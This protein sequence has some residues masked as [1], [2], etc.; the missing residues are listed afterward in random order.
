MGWWLPPL[1]LGIITAG[2]AYCAGVGAIRRLGSRVASFTALLEVLAGVV[3]AWL[4]LGQVP[5]AL[6]ILGAGLLVV[7]KLGDCPLVVVTPDRPAS[8]GPGHER[9]ALHS[10]GR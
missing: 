9:Y 5:S 8:A 2:V 3:F 7:V 6:P 1:A 10:G 4:L